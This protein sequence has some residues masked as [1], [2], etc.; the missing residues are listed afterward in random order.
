M[1][2]FLDLRHELLNAFKLKEIDRAGWINSGLKSVESVASHSWGVSYL[3][4]LLCPKDYDRNKVLSMCIIHDLGEAIIGDITPDDNISKE[5]KYELE[6]SAIKEL[7]KSSEIKTELVDLWLEYENKS[8][9]EALFVKACD[10]LDM[11]LQASIYEIK[12]SD[13][14]PSEFINSAL[15]KIDDECMRI[16]ASS[17]VNGKNPA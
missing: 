1:L 3:A 15:E 16:L 9:P 7:T 4:L 6:F 2:I 14:N 5:E 17:T 11:A 12:N 13:F 8:T 10:S